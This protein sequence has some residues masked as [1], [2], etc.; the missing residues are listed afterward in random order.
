MSIIIKSDINV[1]MSYT[2]GVCMFLKQFM[3]SGLRKYNVI[4]LKGRGALDID[5]YLQLQGRGGGRLVYFEYFDFPSKL[6]ATFYLLECLYFFM[7]IQ[8]YYYSHK[9]FIKS[10]LSK[11]CSNSTFAIRAY[12]SLLLK[13]II[14][15]YAHSF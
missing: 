12:N 1:I 7:T 15:N 6:S 5:R 3:F 11:I 8:S 9:I 14:S 2:E 10:F 4:N 13:H